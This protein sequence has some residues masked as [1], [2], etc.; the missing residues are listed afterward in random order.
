[1]VFKLNI[2]DKGKAWKLETESEF[3]VG[4]NLGDKIQGKEIKPELEGYELEITGGS[5]SAGFPLYNELPGLNLRKVMLKKGWGMKDNTEG[6]RRKKTVRG[7]T[8]STATSLINLKVIKQGSKPLIEI[9]PEQ[10]KPKEK[11][12]NAVVQPALAA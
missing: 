12:T 6:V 10:N 11:K 2:S 3:F 4:K 1:M 7:K 9:F 8:I 5:D